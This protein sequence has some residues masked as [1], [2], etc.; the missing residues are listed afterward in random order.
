MRHGDGYLL[1][2]RDVADVVDPDRKIEQDNGLAANRWQTKHDG[3]E[4]NLIQRACRMRA[5]WRR[6]ISIRSILDRHACHTL[7][8]QPDAMG[9]SR[10]D[11][12]SPAALRCIAAGT[13]SGNVADRYVANG[14]AVDATA[15]ASAWDTEM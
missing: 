1:G 12:G 4:A 11:E 6:D 3:H 7:V 2:S 14:P 15:S 9:D 5:S 13:C 10:A 8:S